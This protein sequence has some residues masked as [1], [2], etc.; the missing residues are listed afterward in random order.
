RVRLNLGVVHLNAGR[1]D[2]A[3]D[4]LFEAKRLYDEG[5][6]IHAFPRIGA[7]IHYNLGAILYIREEYDASMEQMRRAIEIGGHYVALRPRSYAV[8]GYIHMNNENYAAAEEAFTEAI[9]YSR[10]NPE[11][12]HAL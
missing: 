3:Y 7:F 6:S 11:W 5:I 9:K 8:I 4:V 10:D 2:L 1:R 12:L